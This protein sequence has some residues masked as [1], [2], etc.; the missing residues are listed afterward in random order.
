MGGIWTPQGVCDCRKSRRHL[1][2]K[3]SWLRQF[4][5]KVFLELVNYILKMYKLTKLEC[6]H[7][8]KYFVDHTKANWNSNERGVAEKIPAFSLKRYLCKYRVKVCVK[9]TAFFIY[10]CFFRVCDFFFEAPQIFLSDKLT[11]G[12]LLEVNTDNRRIKFPSIWGKNIL[13]L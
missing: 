10:R 1:Y 4:I 2:V 8:W 3:C 9:N 11:M 12:Y 7:V 6:L 13:Y 5:K